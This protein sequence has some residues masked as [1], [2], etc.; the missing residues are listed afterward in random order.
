VVG[1]HKQG[2][3]LTDGWG[4]VINLRGGEIEKFLTGKKSLKSHGAADLPA[5]AQEIAQRAP[6]KRRV[7]GGIE[8]K[9]GAGRQSEEGGTAV[10]GGRRK[11]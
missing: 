10:W 5:K 7:P 11:G 9:A 2:E 1:T 8:G 4:G 3:G 6:P